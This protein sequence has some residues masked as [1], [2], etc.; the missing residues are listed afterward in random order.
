VRRRALRLLALIALLTALTAPTGAAAAP[1]EQAGCQ[2]VLGFAAIR[3]M[4]GA[5]KVGACAE[6]E[7]HNPENGDALQKT[8][9]GLLVWRKADN[10]TAFTDGFWT[11]INGPRGLQ[12]R[13]N[14]ERFEWEGGGAPAAAPRPGQSAPADTSAC[15]GRAAAQV[16]VE[17]QAAAADGAV[18][19]SGTVANRCSEPIDVIVDV[20][21]RS[22]ANSP[23]SRPIADAP[24]AIVTGIE[25]GGSRPFKVTVPRAAGAPAF[26]AD[27]HPVP[28]RL[29]RAVCVDVGATRCLN[30]DRRLSGAVAALLP[31][32]PGRALVQGAA[33][34][35]VS[36]GMAE[37]P[38]SARGAYSTR[39]RVVVIADS[40]MDSTAWVRAAVLVHELQHAADHR[41]GRLPTRAPEDCIRSEE[42]AFRMTVQFWNWIW[43][44]RMPPPVDDMHRSINLLSQTSRDA[45]DRFARG[46]AEAYHDSCGAG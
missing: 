44:E 24:S 43:R 4:V 13:L 37:L 9:G 12:R 17:R 32:E 28:V 18:E 10:L 30:V 26:T 40:L 8:S 20:V 22:A 29:D 21:A 46:I 7:H 14:T 25:V 19:V 33:E 34:S 1:A 35:G 16:V 11:W 23:T 39:R 38:R 2:F 36:I 15:S 6:N 5:D 31:L 41:A 42:A 45:P 27:A 3:D